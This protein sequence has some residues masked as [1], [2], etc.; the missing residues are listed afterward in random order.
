MR[1]QPMKLGRFAAQF[2]FGSTA[3]ALVT[4]ACSYLHAHFATTTFAYLV[5]ILLFSPIGSFIASAALSV[6]CVA[7]L[8]YFFAPPIFS[9]WIDDPQD[10]AVVVTFLV[11][12]IIGSR[13]IGNIREQK[14]A[15]L[16]AEAKLRH[17][18]GDLEKALA[19]LRESEQRFRDYA[20]TA[21]DWLW[22]TGPDHR[23]TR[24]SEHTSTAGIPASSAIGLLREEFAEDVEAEPE[25]WRQ[26]Q[27]MLNAQLPFRDFVYRTT[28]HLES[29]I[30][31]R[32][33]GKPVFDASGDFLGYR[34]VSTDITATIRADH[35]ERA[36]RKAQAELAHVTRVTTLGELAA[37]IAHE[38]N[39]PLAA[40]I[41]NAEACLNWLDRAPSG[42]D[43]ARHS[44]EWIINDANRASEVIH[45]V[46]ALVKKTEIDKTPL[47]L[48][49]IVREAMALVHRE[50]ASHEVSVRMDLTPRLPRIFGDRVQLQQVI[51]N[52]VINAIEA[53]QSVT[54]RPRELAIRSG[55][56]DTRWVFLA[57]ADTGVGLS[58]EDP[59]R[60]FAP[61]STTKSDGM[62]MGLSI[63]RSIIEAHEGQLS[64]ARN[65]GYGATFQFSLPSHQENPS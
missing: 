29:P 61:F 43:K 3:V 36:L 34:G 26:H 45:R 12:S 1:N 40:L 50:L 58:D 39:Q 33:S 35:A 15:A 11:V 28:S 18:Q 41:A 23:I 59:D 46:R 44:A 16:D 24:V 27:A 13:L 22:E 60:M 49:E 65:E 10:L 7:L 30:Y 21:S 48:N 37:S 54:D 31:V 25:K 32:T 8:A 19:A 6:L 20:E 4:Q 55:R 14:E 51:I 2:L 5:V 56:D 57:V 47:T 63:C 52:L 9:I 17:S 42:L 62:G 53:M 64:A 38:L